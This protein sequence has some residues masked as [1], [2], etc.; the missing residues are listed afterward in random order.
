MGIGGSA[1]GTLVMMP[2]SL[3]IMLAA[4]LYPLFQFAALMM[5][6]GWWRL[7]AVPPLVVMVPITVQMVQLFQ[8]GANLAPIVFIMTAPLAAAWLGVFALLR[9]CFAS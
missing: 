2:V 9:R 8:E 5:W 3:A 6:N 1:L 7:A 4:F